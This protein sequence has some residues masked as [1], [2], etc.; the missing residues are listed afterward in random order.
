[1]KLSWMAVAVLGTVAT[2]A[3]GDRTPE[4]T[5]TFE[6]TAPATPADQVGQAP[7]SGTVE[8]SAG[9]ATVHHQNDSTVVRRDA[10]PQ[11]VPSAPARSTSASRPAATAATS[12]TRAA[13]PAVRWREV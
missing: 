1:M 7:T 2:V 10:R 4:N 11:A 9:G 12:A 13:A 3:C 8:P 5:E 6:Q